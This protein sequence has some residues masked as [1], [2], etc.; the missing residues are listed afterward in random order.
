VLVLLVLLA[1][2]LLAVLAAFGLF[3]WAFSG[4]WDGLRPHAEPGDRA[5]VAARSQARGE[6]TSLTADV[7]GDVP[8][9]ELA[10]VRFDQCQQGQNNWKIHDG[11]T[12]RCELAD[13][14]ALSPA[15]GDVTSVSAEIDAGL[16]HDGWVPSGIRNEMSQGAGQNRSYLLATREGRYA[17]S[18]DERL[19][20]TVRVTVRSPTPAYGFLPYDPAVKV[21]GDIEA[22][23]RAVEGAAAPPGSTVPGRAPAPRVVVHTTVRYFEDD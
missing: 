21:E 23:R 14:V 5:V 13:S 20:L 16:Q 8:G 2:L 19:A 3:V 7:L 4:G 6:L 12:L 1:V 17:R 11:Y 9:S 18:D 15:A 22:F 10:R